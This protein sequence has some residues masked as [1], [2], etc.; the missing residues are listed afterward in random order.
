MTF[1][2]PTSALG[3]VGGLYTTL[4]LIIVVIL[5]SNTKK[6]YRETIVSEIK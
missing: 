6:D 4:V 1:K 3:S 2:G 5:G